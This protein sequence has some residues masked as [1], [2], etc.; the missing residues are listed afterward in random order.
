VP[1]YPPPHCPPFPCA[2]QEACT[3]LLNHERELLSQL[4]LAKKV[5]QHADLSRGRAPP[6]AVAS[7]VPGPARRASISARREF[8][9]MEA[10]SGSGSGSGEVETAEGDVL[11]TNPLMQAQPVVRA[12][13]G[14]VSGQRSPGPSSPVLGS[15]SAPTTPVMQPLS[16][17]SPTARGAARGPSLSA[18]RRQFTSQASYDPAAG[19]E[20]PV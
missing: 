10:S 11:S 17:G 6:G 18:S 16:S 12:R 19:Q 7:R 5:G 4:T 15:A 8:S 3:E 2:P 14:S 9:A 20:S 1:L 13:T